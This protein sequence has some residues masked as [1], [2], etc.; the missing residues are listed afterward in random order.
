MMKLSDVNKYVATRHIQE[1]KHHPT[2]KNGHNTHEEQNHMM[3]QISKGKKMNRK[4][5]DK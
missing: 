2:E 3:L 5:Y 1:M 4:N